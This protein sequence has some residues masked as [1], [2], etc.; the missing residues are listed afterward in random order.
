MRDC[1]DI[2]FN[3]L[4]DIE[5]RNNVELL[6]RPVVRSKES[7]FDAVPPSGA[8]VHK[9]RIG[10]NASQLTESAEVV[11]CNTARTPNV[12]DA[13]FRFLGWGGGRYAR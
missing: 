7:L 3:V 9:L 2:V 1:S 12:E 13:R 6:R 4:Q 11:E 5:H 10:L 8:A